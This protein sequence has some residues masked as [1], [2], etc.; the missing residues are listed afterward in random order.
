MRIVQELDASNAV[1]V[2]V[3]AATASVEGLQVDKSAFVEGTALFTPA[4]GVLNDTIS[5]DPTEDQA[6]AFRI[7]P[8]R[9]LH[10]NLRNVSGTEIATATNPLRTDPTGTTAQPVSGTVTAN[11]GTGTMA[12]RETSDGTAYGPPSTSVTGTITALNGEVDLDVTGYSAFAVILSGTWTATPSFQGTVDGTTWTNLKVQPLNGGTAIA[13]TVANGQWMGGCGGLKQV[14]VVATIFTSGTINITLRA[15]RAGVLDMPELPVAAALADTQSNLTTPSIGA[16]NSLYNGSTWDRMR[17]DI[18][19]GLDVDVTRLPS[20][21]AAPASAR[22]SDGSAFYDATKTGQLPAALVSGRLDVNLGAAPATVPVAA[23]KPATADIIVG[24]LSHT[25]TTGA[26]TL[27]TIAAGKTWQ[28]VITV[29]AAGS[30]A[31]ATTGSGE[32]KATIA[33]AGTNVTPAA[34]TVMIVRA[35]MGA[36]AATGV[37]GTQGNSTVTMPITVNAPVGNSVTLTL[38]TDLTAVTVGTVDATASGVYVN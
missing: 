27:L 23:G 11:A 37:T 3:V 13:A 26:T 4:G 2:N 17:G 8:K 32:V 25:T 16:L 12:T 30:K 21:A 15:V 7:T 1:P 9:A 29:C 36:N 38:Q 14:R 10:T 20:T 6:A 31:A 18:T 35:Q 28:G 5:A 22:L 19:N 33:T 24:Q 34:G